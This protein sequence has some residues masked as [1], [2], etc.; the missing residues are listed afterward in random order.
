MATYAAIKRDKYR[1]TTRAELEA[2]NNY[3][4]HQHIKYLRQRLGWLRDKCEDL[5][6]ELERDEIDLQDV[7]HC[8]LEMNDTLHLFLDAVTERKKRKAAAI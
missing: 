1:P 7:Y 8:I 5:A 2:L 6:Y 3:E 4:L